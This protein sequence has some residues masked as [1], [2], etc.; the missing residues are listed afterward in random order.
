[1]WTAGG[2][3][4]QLF[5]L[6]KA[7]ELKERNKFVMLDTYFYENDVRYER[8]F[9]FKGKLK[10]I[11]VLNKKLRYILFRLNKVLNKINM[12]HFQQESN[13]EKSKI[14]FF[15]V[16]YL[17]GYWQEKIVPKKRNI[18]LFNRVFKENE[19]KDENIVAVHFRSEEYD[20]KLPE[21][22]Y[23]KA[24][25]VFD[26]SNYEFHLFGD[27]KEYL[28]EIEKEIFKN[29]K[30]KIIDLNDEILEFEKL[31]S[32]RNYI[33]SNSTFCWWALI[34]NQENILKA[35]SPKKWNVGYEEKYNIY[36]PSEWELV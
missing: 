11:T 23:S 6:N 3:G 18:D 28:K 16:I 32:Y 22:Y 17:T 15:Q 7:L 21:S 20:I 10:I 4:N 19:L 1:M 29:K 36:I 5:I 9:H 8:K 12:F 27:S 26:E 13:F 35:T 31:K 34:L 33:S 25:K 14:K 24:L 2:L 30:S